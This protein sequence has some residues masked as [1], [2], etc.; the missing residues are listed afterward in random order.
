MGNEVSWERLGR[1]MLELERIG[2][3]NI[4]FVTPSHYVPQ[5]R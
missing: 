4:N 2:C 3:H 1:M 5:I